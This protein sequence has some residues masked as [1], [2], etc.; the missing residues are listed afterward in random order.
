ME[1]AFR[2]RMMTN[3][4]AVRMSSDD[5]YALSA[6]D[7][8]QGVQRRRF[9]A[10]AVLDSV[11]ARVQALNPALNAIIGFDP[12]AARAEARA[13]DRHLQANA[14]A[15]RLPL[16]GVPI[17]VKDNIW[18][19]GRRITQGSRL[20]ADFIA[21]RDAWAVA[22]A[23]ALGAVVLGITNC[24]EFACKG[25]T[26]NLLHGVTRSP[27]DRTLTPGGSSGGAA[28]AVA[29]GFGPLALVTDA[30]G[31]TRRPAAHCGLVGMK[32]SFGLVPYGPG[33]EEPNFGISVIGQL[34]RTVGD[35][36]LLLDALRAWHPADPASQPVAMAPVHPRL[37]AIAPGL[38][39]GFSRTLG[40]DFAID[41]DV[42]QQ[43]EDGVAQLRRAGFN[44][45]DADP[46]WPEG[47]REYPLLALQH[48]G[49]DALHGAALD[50]DASR[51]D[52]DLQVQI[53]AG[54]QYS[55]TDLARLLLLRERIA[56]ALSSF[57]ERY[58]LLLCPTAPVTSWPIGKLGPESIGGRPAGP[59]GHAAFTPL[60]NYC[61]VPACSVP[62][63]LVRGL[64]VGMQ[65]VGPRYRD[66]LVL[67]F[68]RQIELACGW[69]PKI[70]G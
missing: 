56:G 69:V 42:L 1:L 66:D 49:L 54:R 64:P 44:I 33:F 47:A 23:R 38:R 67:Q 57:F 59:R 7:I 45:A 16:A 62:A 6:A 35:A 46:A 26:E 28:S 2:S 48:A 12:E 39:I 22:R 37:D 70:V 55:G 61:G 8:A 51:I 36:A 34:A 14:D 52:P 17:T 4:G 50:Q 29:A 60:F 43:F 15:D 20:F 40:C 27:W 21:P 30:G 58:D 31:S 19:A 68:A 5:L 24:S 3:Q 53:R 9:S 32:P 10:S 65:V 13:I 41:A 18:V 11:I 63:G 25:V